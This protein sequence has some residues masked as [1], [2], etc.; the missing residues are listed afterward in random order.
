MTLSNI[1]LNKQAW[2]YYL[3]KIEMQYSG[4]SMMFLKML[5]W[6]NIC[7]FHIRSTYEFSFKP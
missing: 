7:N 5:I 6:A 2:Q 3:I 4:Y 1:K